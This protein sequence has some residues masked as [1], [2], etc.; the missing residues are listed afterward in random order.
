MELKELTATQTKTEFIKSIYNWLMRTLEEHGNEEYKDCFQIEGS[1]I[2]CSLPDNY[3]NIYN[4][5]HNT[6]IEM[7]FISKKG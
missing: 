7:K 2:M 5:P 6:K 3:F 1:S 4:I